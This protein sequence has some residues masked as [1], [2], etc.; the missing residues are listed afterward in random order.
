MDKPKNET[1]IDTPAWD[2][3]IDDNTVLPE[4]DDEWWDDVLMSEL[5]SDDVDAGKN[6]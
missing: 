6:D 1:D 4:P 2:E 5:W 3:P